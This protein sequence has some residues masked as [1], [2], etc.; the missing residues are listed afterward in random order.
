MARL[1]SLLAVVILI[2]LGAL[3]W[4]DVGNPPPPPW[5]G[6]MQTIADGNNRFAIDIYG[7]LREKEGNLF[8]SPYSI[9]TA[10][11]M[12]TTG[13]R[14]STRDEMVKVLHLPADDG[15]MLASGDFSGY[16]AHPR[17]EFE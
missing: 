11:T 2:V 1:L 4:R 10:L 14:G 12:T 6:D 17:K 13:A 15:K 7:K 3:A 5:T 9:H 16:Y 8:F